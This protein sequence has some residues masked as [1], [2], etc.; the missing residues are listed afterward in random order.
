[1][2]KGI[3]GGIKFIREG[4]L[5]AHQNTLY[6]NKFDVNPNSPGGFYTT[7]RTHA[8]FYQQH[9]ARHVFLEEHM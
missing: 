4:Y 7:H 1:M 9:I 5:D 6:L 2:Q 8:E 3:E